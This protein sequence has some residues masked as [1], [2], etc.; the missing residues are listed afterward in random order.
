MISL[1]TKVFSQYYIC[2]S[3]NIVEDDRGSYQGCDRGFWNNGVTEVHID[4]TAIDYE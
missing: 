1:G 2:R 4:T 3:S